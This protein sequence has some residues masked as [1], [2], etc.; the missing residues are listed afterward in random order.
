MGSVWSSG[1]NKQQQQNRGKFL[2]NC[3]NHTHTH[4]HTQLRTKQYLVSFLSLCCS[5]SKLA[6]LFYMKTICD[7][8][9]YAK[10]QHQ[11]YTYMYIYYLSV[12]WLHLSIFIVGRKKNRNNHTYRDIKCCALGCM[13]CVLAISN[14]KT[15]KIILNLYLYLYMHSRPFGIVAWIS[16]PFRRKK[17]K[18]K[19]NQL[20]QMHI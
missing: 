1:D 10:I 18:T 7:C 19:Q 4:T 11:T 20:K 17:K 6:C 12:I 14:A 16:R 9:I 2:S 13:A 8:M 3:C 15:S 5:T